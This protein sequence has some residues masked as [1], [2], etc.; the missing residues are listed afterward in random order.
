MWVRS[1]L[2]NTYLCLPDEQWGTCEL[3]NKGLLECCIIKLI[4]IDNNQ[5]YLDLTELII[6]FTLNN[7]HLRHGGQSNKDLASHSTNSIQH[8]FKYYLKAG[9]FIC[10]LTGSFS[11]LGKFL[12]L[13]K[14][15]K[16]VGFFFKSKPYVVLSMILNPQTLISILYWT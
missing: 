15:S 10:V 6:W 9:Y 16:V 2:I 4:I 5:P 12:D 13:S 7:V 14:S 11:V 1:F 8:I 3:L